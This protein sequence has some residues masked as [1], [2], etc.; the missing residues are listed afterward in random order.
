[1]KKFHQYTTEE[2]NNIVDRARKIIYKLRDRC[3]NKNF[4]QYKDYGGNGISIANEWNDMDTFS[5]DIVKLDGFD[6]ALFIS[7]ELELDKDLK[8]R[9]N[10]VYSK[11]TCYLLT[12]KENAQYKPSVHDDIYAYNQYTEEI[13]EHISLPLF[14]L[15]ERISLST[16][17]SVLQGRK[18]RSGDWYIWRKTD[19]PP[20]VEKVFARK[21]SEEVWDINPQQLSQKIGANRAG[22]SGALRT[23]YKL[24]GY[25]ITKEIVNIQDL[26]HNYELNKMPNDY[27]TVTFHR[28]DAKGNLVEYTFKVE[29]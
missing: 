6:Y 22:C 19:N 26:V 12:R 28:E 10:K 11:D 24:F 8:V 14:C 29:M 20:I 13:K 16:A 4:K 25:R 21:D 27:R 7:G 3:N 5:R 18:H 15:E 2:Q 23:G 1:M 9:N 17:N